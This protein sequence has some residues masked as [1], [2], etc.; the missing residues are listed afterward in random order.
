MGFI[1]VDTMDLHAHPLISTTNRVI[2]TS[3]SSSSVY[4]AGK[5]PAPT[6]RQAKRYGIHFPSLRSLVPQS[7]IPAV[8][9]EDYATSWEFSTSSLDLN[10]HFSLEKSSV[11][12]I[13]AED[14]ITNKHSSIDT[15]SAGISNFLRNPEIKF[16]QSRF[17][18]LEGAVCQSLLIKLGIFSFGNS[19]V[20][21]KL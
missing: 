1:P 19:A 6:S 12:Y 20:K 16:R 14:V 9:A 15:C 7:P 4:F 10:F 13:P 11:N 3:F 17:L 2:T 18:E 5:R 8:S 21:H